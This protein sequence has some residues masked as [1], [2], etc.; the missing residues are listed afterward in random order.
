MEKITYKELFIETLEEINKRKWA[1]F[2]L[3]LLVVLV[4]YWAM[5]VV[6]AKISIFQNVILGVISYGNIAIIIILFYLFIIFDTF[7]IYLLRPDEEFMRLTFSQVI[8]DGSKYLWKTMALSIILLFVLVPSYLFFVLP[9]IVLS[10]YW[11]FSKYLIII[12][13]E[14]VKDSLFDSWKI[15]KKKWWQIFHYVCLTVVML[16][17]I[18]ILLLVSIKLLSDIMIYYKFIFVLVEIMKF[19]LEVYMIFL[20]VFITAF[21]KRLYLSTKISGEEYDSY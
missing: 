10:I 14:S 16:S 9:G 13:Q 15:I 21:S 5:K 19:I 12:D 1:I 7:I 2:L 18:A 11:I 6:F 20:G 4:P 17:V 3:S 8:R